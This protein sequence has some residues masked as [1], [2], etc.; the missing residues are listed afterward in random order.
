MP[1]IVNVTYYKSNKVVNQVDNIFTEP[2]TETTVKKTN[3]NKPMVTITNY[4]PYRSTQSTEPKIFSRSK[5]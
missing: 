2:D 3:S 5:K 1:V 4:S